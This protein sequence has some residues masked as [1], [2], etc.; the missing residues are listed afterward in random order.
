MNIILKRVQKGLFIALLAIFP[1]FAMHQLPQKLE[2]YF[3]LLPVDLRIELC[4][5]LAQTPTNPRENQSFQLASAASTLSDFLKL[6]SNAN[7]LNNKEL[8]KKLIQ[9]LADRYTKDPIEAALF[10]NTPESTLFLVN[11][12]GFNWNVSSKILDIVPHLE[13]TTLKKA[14]GLAKHCKKML[15]LPIALNYGWHGAHDINYTIDYL[16][17]GLAVDFDQKEMIGYLKSY[18]YS[19]VMK[20]PDDWGRKFKYEL[21]AAALLGEYGIGWLK[22]KLELFKKEIELDPK[23]HSYFGERLVDPIICLL[24]DNPHDISKFLIESIDT[25]Y[26][27]ILLEVDARYSKGKLAQ[28]SLKAMVLY[29]NNPELLKAIIDMLP[30]KHNV[31]CAEIF[32]NYVKKH[33]II[34]L[35]LWKVLVAA[36][37]ID[38][39][40]QG[41]GKTLLM[42]AIERGNKDLVK[43]ILSNPSLNLARCDDKGHNALWYAQQLTINKFEIMEI[44]K[45]AGA[46]EREACDIQ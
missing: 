45:K 41:E 21:Q 7:L 16:A 25:K 29:Q 12:L 30:D 22:R 42:L 4:S 35:A 9:E 26:W 43:I 1:A 2:A 17:A 20:Y 39:N 46:H 3:D 44:L 37:N 32:L 11:R 23:A 40:I 8:T 24:V 10:L 38:C 6:P 36:P 14:V 28:A 15:D 18:Y 31:N 5:Y 33:S 34:D 13:G 19:N 27:R